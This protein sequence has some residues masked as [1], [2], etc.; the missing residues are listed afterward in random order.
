[1]CKSI[2]HYWVY[3]YFILILFFMVVWKTETDIWELPY[4]FRDSKRHWIAK[5]HWNWVITSWKPICIRTC[6]YNLWTALRQETYRPIGWLLCRATCRPHCAPCVTR[7]RRM[8]KYLGCCC[9]AEHRRTSGRICWDGRLPFAFTLT[10]A[11]TIWWQYC[12]NSA[13]P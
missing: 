10:K 5:R 6:H 1:M 12:W 13:P 7:T 4:G 11:F 9:S 3:F 8:S 2:C